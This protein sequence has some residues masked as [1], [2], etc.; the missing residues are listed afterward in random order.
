VLHG[1][2]QQVLFELA[3]ELAV[4]HVE[5]DLTAEKLAAADEVFLTSTSI[6]C[7]QWSKWMAAQSAMAVQ[8]LFTA[9]C[10]RLGAITWNL[11]VAGQAR[12]FANERNSS[13]PLQSCEIVR[14]RHFQRLAGDGRRAA[15]K[16][17]IVAD[18]P[19]QVRG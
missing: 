11:D 10:S 16:L 3:D 4:P 7:C 6:A 18:L 14:H 15:M 5:A 17:A 1:I 19:Q 12:R 9:A 2:S 13:H 8:A